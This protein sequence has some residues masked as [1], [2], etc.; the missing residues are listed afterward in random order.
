MSGFANAGDLVAI[1]NKATS[2]DKSKFG[3]SVKQ[4]V[5]GSVPDRGGRTD[6]AAAAAAGAEQAHGH[7]KFPPKSG[8]GHGHG[9]SG[10]GASSKKSRKH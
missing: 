5:I 4:L 3:A 8:G 10:K 2:G 1:G 6:T 7:K 9:Q